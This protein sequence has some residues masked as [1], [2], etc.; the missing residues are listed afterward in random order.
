MEIP[1]D[2]SGRDT[3]PPEVMPAHEERTR[4]GHVT[5][6]LSFDPPPT[7]KRSPQGVIVGAVIVLILVL[8]V[9]LA[10]TRLGDDQDPSSEIRVIPPSAFPAPTL[11]VQVSPSPSADATAAAST[12]ATGS[13]RAQPSRTEVPRDT[14]ETNKDPDTTD[15][16]DAQVTV[17]QGE[18]GDEDDQ[19][20][21]DGARRSGD[22]K[23]GEHV[24]SCPSNDP[25]C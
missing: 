14:E 6:P 1:V 10:L 4:P 21:N 13:R 19:Q 7:P 5:M 8:I 20:P 11:I 23:S 12:G 25:E 16:D 24:S 17:I 15:N 22:N 3:L 2:F 18:S 9:F